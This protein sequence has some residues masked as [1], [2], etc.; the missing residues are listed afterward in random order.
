MTISTDFLSLECLLKW[1]QNIVGKS[2]ALLFLGYENV[3]KFLGLS[4]LQLHGNEK[5]YRVDL[6]SLRRLNRMAYEEPLESAE[7]I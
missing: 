3:G 4:V 6:M 7:Q 5:K 2:D 1:Q